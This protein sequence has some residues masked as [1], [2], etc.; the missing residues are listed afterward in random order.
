MGWNDTD[1]ERYPVFN[2]RTLRIQ[3]PTDRS[4]EPYAFPASALP[5]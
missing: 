5:S 2:D 3:L 1:P 4:R